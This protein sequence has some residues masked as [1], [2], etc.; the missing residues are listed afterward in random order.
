MQFSTVQ[1]FPLHL[2][3]WFE[4]DGGGQSHG[5]ADIESLILAFGTNGLDT[6]GVSG[7]HGEEKI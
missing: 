1:K 3:A 5:K 6:Q 7:L 2:I 4:A